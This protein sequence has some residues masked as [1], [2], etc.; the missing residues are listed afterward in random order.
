M[1]IS[2]G[3]LHLWTCATQFDY[4]ECG[5]L[6]SSVTS[7]ERMH[8]YCLFNRAEKSRQT[9]IRILTMNQ[10]T[11]GSQ[12][13]GWQYFLLPAGYIGVSSLPPNY[14]GHKRSTLFVSLRSHQA[15]EKHKHKR[16]LNILKQILQNLLIKQ[17]SQPELPEVYMRNSGRKINK[18]LLWCFL[19]AQVTL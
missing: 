19:G 18:I 8:Y 16:V 12:R 13:K 6:E 11:W 15:K 3:F 14:K 17:F 4:H 5:S 7:R 2:P 1:T 10:M 9:Q